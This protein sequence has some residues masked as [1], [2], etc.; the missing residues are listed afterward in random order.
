MAAF[1]DEAPAGSRVA[2]DAPRELA[3]SETERRAIMDRFARIVG[4]SGEQRG[5]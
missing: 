4:G 2:E 1:G 3:R 5:S